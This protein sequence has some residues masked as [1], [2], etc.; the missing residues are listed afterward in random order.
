MMR[1]RTTRVMSVEIKV[2]MSGIDKRMMR[3]LIIYARNSFTRGF[4]QL[5]RRSVPPKFGAASDVET[6]NNI[7]RDG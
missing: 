6:K 3:E 1:R 2:K 5:L 4:S 7:A